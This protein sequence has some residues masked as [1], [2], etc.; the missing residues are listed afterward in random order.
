[1]LVY[2][3][4]F[5]FACLADLFDD[6]ANQNYWAHQAYPDGHYQCKYALYVPSIVFAMELFKVDAPNWDFTF[7]DI[8]DDLR[9]LFGA[10]QQFSS[11]TSGVPQLHIDVLRYRNGRGGPTF[12][13]SRGSLW[14]EIPVATNASVA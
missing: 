12:L 9:A 4:S 13:A 3:E 8:A 6:I 7:S 11:P 1:M 5:M 14:T 2:V 10:F